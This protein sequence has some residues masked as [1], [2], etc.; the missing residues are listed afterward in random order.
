MRALTPLFALLLSSLPLIVPA[1][2]ADDPDKKKDPPPPAEAPAPPGSGIAPIA[3]APLVPPELD[4][5]IKVN[6]ELKKLVESNGFTLDETGVFTHKESGVKVHREMLKKAGLDFD[7]DGKLVY[8]KTGEPVKDEHVAPALKGLLDFARVAQYSPAD[9]GKKLQ[10]WGV[11]PSHDG[12]HLLNPD[13]TAT[14]FGL[15]LYDSVYKDPERLNK[16]SGERLSTSLSLFNDAHSTA[17]GFGNS[18]PDAAQAHLKRA[19]ELLSW[20]K[21]KPGET[22]LKLKPYSDVGEQFRTYKGKLEAAAAKDPK[23]KAE[24]AQYIAA[25]NEMEKT[26]YHKYLDLADTIPKPTSGGGPGK[27]LSLLGK[28]E[29]APAPVQRALPGL[30]KMFDKL[31]GKPMSAEQQEA[32]IKSF[33]M[34]ETVWRMGAQELWKEGLTGKDVKVGVIDTGVGYAP[35]LKGVVDSRETFTLQQGGGAVGSHA[36][37]VAGIIHALAPEARIN[38]YQALEE[39]SFGDKMA[40]RDGG[41]VD[42]RIMD[43]VDK[44]V[45]D[46]NHV[47][48]MSLGG[49]GVPSGPLAAKIQEYAE[50]GVVFVV[51]AGNSANRGVSTPSI[52]KD[53]ITVGS[54]DVNGRMSTYSSYGDIWDPTTMSFAI[55]NVFMAPGQNINSTTG[56]GTKENSFAR[57]SGTSMAAPATAGTV[58]Q[59]F[60]Y[61]RNFSGTASPVEMS[62]RIQGAL[63]GG[64]HMSRREL[65]PDVPS[66]QDFIIVDGVKAYRRL[67]GST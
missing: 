21:A 59:L 2:A 43:A 28:D 26:R 40:V 57:Y 44:A 24:M 60:Q 31:N 34:G 12:I 49:G 15:M 54:L 3:P 39:G 50:K 4:K 10:S 6:D 51:S 18:R 14:Y 47:I 56:T 42:K 38:S 41:V 27:P 58:T 11:P 53:A 16:L 48:N 7:K 45:A 5:K 61:V 22:V 62:R 25:L 17:F 64:E 23:S 29:P 35:E 52:A 9:I 19:Q 66:E 67:R 20:D 30:L 8:Q 36:T 46:G 1:L 37:H 13:G 32:F 55:K 63:Q 65:P 33:P